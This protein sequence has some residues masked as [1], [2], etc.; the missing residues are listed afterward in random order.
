M[1]RHLLSGWVIVIISLQVFSASHFCSAGWNASY[2]G[3]GQVDTIW[4]T[5]G[6]GPYSEHCPRHGHT[7]MVYKIALEFWWCVCRHNQSWWMAFSSNSLQYLLITLVSL[8]GSSHHNQPELTTILNHTMDLV[9]VV[10][11]AC[12]QTMTPAHAASYHHCIAS[13]VGKLKEVYPTLNAWPNHHAAFHIY[14]Y[15]LLFGSVHAW[16]SF[17]FEHLIGILQCL[18]TNHQYGELQCSYTITLNI[19][20]F[21]QVNWK[22]PWSS[23][24]WRQQ[25]FE[26]GFVN[27]SALLL[28]IN[29]TFS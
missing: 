12:A 3:L 4:F 18:P 22:Q 14:D 29:A 15:L 27:P 7:I 9:S 23:R 24:I 8:W 2:F 5:R 28:F 20:I 25:N 16:W 17:P 26:G 19:Y 21:E 11:L 13:Y 6:L 10:Y 1:Q